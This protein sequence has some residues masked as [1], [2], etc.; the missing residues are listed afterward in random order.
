[1]ISVYSF[2][3]HF[4]YLHLLLGHLHTIAFISIFVIIISVCQLISFFSYL[5]K[6]KQSFL[7]NIIERVD[8]FYVVSIGGRPLI[9]SAAYLYLR[10][11]RR[12]EVNDPRRERVFPRP[13]AVQSTQQPAVKRANRVFVSM[14]TQTSAALHAVPPYG[15]VLAS[16]RWRNTSLGD[17]LKGR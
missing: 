11:R 1:M 13:L 17:G 16:E 4:L 9:I 3:A 8:V 12:S 5:T 6:E 2:F 7:Y 14:E 10:R 15:H